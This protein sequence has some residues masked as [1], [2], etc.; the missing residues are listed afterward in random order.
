MTFRSF[1]Y[2]H[3]EWNFLILVRFQKYRIRSSRRLSNRNSFRKLDPVGTNAFQ[4]PRKTF[5]LMYGLL[6]QSGFSQSKTEREIRSRMKLSRVIRYTRE[7]HGRSN[8]LF[9]FALLR[10]FM[11]IEP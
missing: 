6:C 1:S 10:N 4:T 5:A 9:V 2:F 8:Y 11:L 7:I 3:F